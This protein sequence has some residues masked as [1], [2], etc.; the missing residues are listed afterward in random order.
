VLLGSHAQL[1]EAFKLLKERC[2]ISD[3]HE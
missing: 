1:N 3:E 2:P